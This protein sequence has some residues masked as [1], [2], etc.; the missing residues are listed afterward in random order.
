MWT[1]QLELRYVLYSVKKQ[2]PV[3]LC[4][5]WPY[6]VQLLLLRAEHNDRN[7]KDRQR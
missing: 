5:L 3:K 6:V 7:D 4:D 2:I 1:I